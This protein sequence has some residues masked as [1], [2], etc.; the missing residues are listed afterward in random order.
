MQ[1]LQFLYPY[2]RGGTGGDDLDGTREGDHHGLTGGDDDAL[3]GHPVPTQAAE[4]LLGGVE[5]LDDDSLGTP[6]PLA[7]SGHLDRTWSVLATKTIQIAHGKALLW[8]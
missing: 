7:P 4:G 1:S 3:V 8:R 6:T 5:V 2:R